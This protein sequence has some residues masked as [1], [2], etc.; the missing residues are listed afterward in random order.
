MVSFLMSSD[1]RRVHANQ[2]LWSV[3]PSVICTANTVI[4]GYVNRNF[5]GNLM[6]LDGSNLADARDG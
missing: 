4:R 6:K 1:A 5:L 2:L 3:H